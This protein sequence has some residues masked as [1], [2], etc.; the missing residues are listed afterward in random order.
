M[1]LFDVLMLICVG[2]PTAGAISLAT[3]L[4]PDLAGYAV[5]ILVNVLLGCVLV[6]IMW[7]ARSN[8]RRSSVGAGSRATWQVYLLY[9]GALIWIILAFMLG[10]LTAEMIF[11]VL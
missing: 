7:V 6:W 10:T 8:A 2:M 1:T 11:S 9:Y 4:Q 5:A 3:V